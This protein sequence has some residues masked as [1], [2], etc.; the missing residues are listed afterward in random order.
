MPLPPAARAGAMRTAYARVA[1]TVRHAS[2]YRDLRRFLH[3]LRSPRVR[4]LWSPANTFADMA[5]GESPYPDGYRAVEEQI[6]HIHLKDGVRSPGGF[7]PCLFGAGGVDYAGLLGELWENSY[8]GYLALEPQG[9][10]LGPG[11][12]EAATAA[13]LENLR[14]LIEKLSP[15]ESAAS[16]ADARAARRGPPVVSPPGY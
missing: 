11:D 1:H 14:R 4:A 12:G 13:A 15:E 8:G 6:V 2:R 10:A 3:E 7:Q 5:A 16:A 9:R